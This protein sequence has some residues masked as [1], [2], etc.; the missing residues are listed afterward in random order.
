MKRIC[1]IGSGT[2]EREEGIHVLAVDEGTGAIDVRRVLKRPNAL[3]MALSRDGARL[4]A[5]QGGPTGLAAYRV[6][7]DGLEQFDFVPTAETV[8]CHVGLAPDGGALAFAEYAHGTAGLVELDAAGAFVR[9][10]MKTV[11]LS[12]PVGPNQPRQDR[13]HAHCSLFTPEGRNLCVVDLGTD[14][15]KIYDR[16]M[17]EVAAKSFVTAPPGA[18]PRH[19]AFHPNGKFAFVVFEL[20][21]LVTSYR[22]ADG[23]FAPLQQLPLLPHDFKEFSK[24]AAIRIS[25]DGREL[26]CSNRGHDSIAAFAVDPGTGY[27]TPKGIMSLGG[28]FPRDFTFLPGGRILLACLKMSSIV[29]TYRYDPAKVA[30]TPLAEKG[31]FHRPLHVTVGAAEGA[32]AKG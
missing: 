12:D 30:L 3:Y 19:V 16:R 27:L 14:R 15:V 25:A 17:E 24:A 5:A 2:D 1:Y 6:K 21:N 23:S 28:A 20:L 18:G 22:Y 4:Y 7:G 13:P 9:G 26:F 31:G 8:P 29:R 11:R 10:S 32:A